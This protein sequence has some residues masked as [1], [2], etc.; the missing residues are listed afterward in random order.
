M[1]GYHSKFDWS[2]MGLEILVVLLIL[3]EIV[4]GGEVLHRWKV[5]KRIKSLLALVSAG[6]RLQR[7]VPGFGYSLP[8]VS[9]EVRGKWDGDVAS[10]IMETHHILDSYSEQ[11]AAKFSDDSTLKY[12]PEHENIEPT[13]WKTY[14]S[15]NH[16]VSN[17]LS[18]MQHP[19]VYF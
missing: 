18:I 11:A 19:E 12:A 5:R 9:M 13:C 3:W 4:F 10:W 17:L 8:N 2:M 15:L 6:Q 14:D 1:F 7:S 16:R